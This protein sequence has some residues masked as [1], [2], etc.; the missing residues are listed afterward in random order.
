MSPRETD[1]AKLYDSRLRAAQGHTNQALKELASVEQSADAFIAAQAT[2][3]RVDLQI[4]ANKSKYSDA[5]ETLEKLRFRWRGDDLEL[6]TLRKL[7]SL[8]YAKH[9]WRNGM[10]EIGRAHV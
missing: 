8:Y 3:A 4:A 9:D 10:A 5:S 2:Y 6:Q 1:E 7:G